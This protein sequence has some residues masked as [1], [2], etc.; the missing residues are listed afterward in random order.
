MASNNHNL[1]DV[2]REFFPK[3][4]IPKGIKMLLLE[5][6]REAHPITGQ[7]NPHSVISDPLMLRSFLTHARKKGALNYMGI[8]DGPTKGKMLLT[9]T[10]G[11]SQID[12]NKAKFLVSLLKQPHDVK[13]F[14][15]S[16]D[17]LLPVQKLQE[18]KTLAKGR[19]KRV[20]FHNNRERNFRVTD[21]RVL[22]ALLSERNAR[23]G[24]N[25]LV[26]DRFDESTSTLHLSTPWD[27]DKVPTEKGKVK[28][29]GDLAAFN[30]EGAEFLSTHFSLA[31]TASRHKLRE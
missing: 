6:T 19:I 5:K 15:Q 17:K 11:I 13:T 10:Q 3:T 7:I 8:S 29:P 12:T 25:H 9:F 28:A 23:F 27:L 4:T 30:E 18:I 14:E 16:F 2:L 20:E 24:L 21:P 31:T 1:A 26:I 22:H